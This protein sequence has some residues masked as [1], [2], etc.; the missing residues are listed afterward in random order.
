[1]TDEE[2]ASALI[3]ASR[4]MNDELGHY[5]KFLGD[6]YGLMG[7]WGYDLGV[8]YIE[9]LRRE[10]RRLGEEFRWVEWTETKTVV[11]RELRHETE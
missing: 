8:A 2:R 1:M 4:H 9:E 6:A 5:W 11:H 3:E 10:H 7:K